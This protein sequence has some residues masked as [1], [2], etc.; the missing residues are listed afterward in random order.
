MAVGIGHAGR[1]ASR[2][3][4][5]RDRVIRRRDRGE[6][7]I[8][9]VHSRDDLSLGVDRCREIIRPVI[10]EGGGEG[11]ARGDT[12]RLSVELVVGKGGGRTPG[13]GKGLDI[14]FPVIGEGLETCKSISDRGEGIGPCLRY[15]LYRFLI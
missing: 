10:G 1:I 3:V 14:A 6:T 7:G 9:V 13:I 4:A 11:A 12:L 5:D 15:C 2:I 8:M